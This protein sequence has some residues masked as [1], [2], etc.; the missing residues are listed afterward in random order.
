MECGINNVVYYGLTGFIWHKPHVLLARVNYFLL[1]MSF[2]LV[3][4]TIFV[5]VIT[6]IMDLSDWMTICLEKMFD[7][8]ITIANNTSNVIS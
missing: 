5:W 8:N 4:Y 3:T 1:S 2:H 6:F 7:K